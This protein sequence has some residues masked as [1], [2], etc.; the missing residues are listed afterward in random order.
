[1]CPPGPRPRSLFS[2]CPL[3]CSCVFAHCFRF[4]FEQRQR[5]TIGHTLAYRHST[6]A[7]PHLHTQHLHFSHLHFWLLLLLLLLLLEL[8]VAAAGPAFVYAPQLGADPFTRLCLWTRFSLGT[9]AHFHLQLLYP[10]LWVV[11]VC[12][13]VCVGGGGENG[14]MGDCVPEAFCFLASYLKQYASLKEH[15]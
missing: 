8:L 15:A 13:S 5:Q 3:C 6:L 11:C 14:L 7:H 4:T 9:L 10:P 12:V 1:M 2:S